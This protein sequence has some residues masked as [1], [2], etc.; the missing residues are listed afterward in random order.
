M[1]T[2]VR[3]MAD[4]AG[5]I[6]VRLSQIRVNKEA[7]SKKLKNY[8]DKK[9]WTNA[10]LSA[11]DAL[12]LAEVSYL[13]HEVRDGSATAVGFEKGDKGVREFIGAGDYDKRTPLHI[14]AA[15]GSVEICRFLVQKGA[16]ETDRDE[17]D[18]LVNVTDR[19]DG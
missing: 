19:F 3:T 8:T 17:M 6:S 1:G 4:E 14:A 11:C 16:S 12:N 15:A 18:K 13:V 9:E 7:V 5:D 2:N 10:L